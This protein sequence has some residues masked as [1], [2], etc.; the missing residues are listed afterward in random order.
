MN[1]R[2]A[3]NPRHPVRSSA[4][5]VTHRRPWAVLGGSLLVAALLAPGSTAAVR[6]PHS[7]PA[8][9]A[10]EGSTGASGA[11]AL[12][13]PTTADIAL[14]QRVGSLNS[15]VFITSA[16]DGTDRF[17]IV[18]QT[19]RIKIW[20]PGSGV[21]STPFLSLVGEVS[22]AF[23]RGL[24]GLAFH[25][26]YETN[27]RLYVYFTR[28]DG[29]IVVREYKARLSNPNRVNEDSARLVL[30]IEHSA[31]NNHNGGML[32]FGPDGNLYLGTG[33]GGGQD[34]PNNRGQRT[35]TL[36]GKMLRIDVDGRTG[37]KGYGI[38][39]SNPYVGEPGEN[40]IW[41]IGLRNPWRFSFDSATDNLWIGDVGQRKWEEIDRATDT[42]SGPGR[43][44]NWGWRVLEGTHCFIPSSG[45]NTS[46]KTMPVTEYE[47]TEANGRCSVS[48]GYVYRGSAI[49]ALVGGYVF[50]DYCTGEI[51]VISAGASNGVN[52]TLLLNTSANISSFGER[53]N[54]ELF[55]VDHGG[56]IYSIVQG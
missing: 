35:D 31:N 37:N 56:R 11:V 36:L 30:R 28:S 9:A 4:R 48:G 40:E 52:P 41:Q 51:W 55:V 26:D 19:G 24:L 8:A 33:D 32:L 29:D 18:E 42:A 53:P 10:P 22:L 15:P 14:D 34:D 2:P 43:G 16:R 25:P 46:G 1:D 13:I 27:R 17:F 21:R 38:P 23:E 12:G 39:S 20:V 7:E 5:R 44:I 47:H 45:C 54:G 6:P 50:G 49:P 3:P